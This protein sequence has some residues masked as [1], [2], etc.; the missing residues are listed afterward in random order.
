MLLIKITTGTTAPGVLY[1]N[2]GGRPER[3]EGYV[4]GVGSWTKV[5]GVSDAS[6]TVNALPG[7]TG[8]AANVNDVCQLTP[9]GFKLGTSTTWVALASAHMVIRAQVDGL[10]NSVIER[11]VDLSSAVLGS[12]DARWLNPEDAYAYSDG[13]EDLEVEWLRTA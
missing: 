5:D 10:D 7:G 2:C 11:E 12:G 13:D 3:V 1:V 4:F 8:N 6:H 9:Y